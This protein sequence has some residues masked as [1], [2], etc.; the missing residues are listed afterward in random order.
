MKIAAAILL[1]LLAAFV[2]YSTV[3]GRYVSLD[4]G[5]HLDRLTGEAEFRGKT[6]RF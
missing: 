6:L 3:G 5:L 2:A 1:G 4:N